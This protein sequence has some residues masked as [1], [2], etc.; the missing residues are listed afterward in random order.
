MGRKHYLRCS[1][2]NLTDDEEYVEREAAENV[3]GAREGHTETGT[4][5]QPLHLESMDTHNVV[6]AAGNGDQAPGTQYDGG[7]DSA[8]K[9]TVEIAAESWDVEA[10]SLFLA[11]LHCQNAQV[12]RKLGPKMQDKVAV[13]ADY[14]QCKEVLGLFAELW[15]PFL[16]ELPTTYCRNLMLCLWV[17]WFFGLPSQFQPL[18]S[19]AMSQSSFSINNVGLPI[20]HSGIDMGDT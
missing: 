10:P 17:S 7:D 9:G 2:S 14:Y 3:P 5:S 12:P 13:L 18:T 6:N 20:P 16:E 19:T 15:F 8:K 11:V 1:D 4:V